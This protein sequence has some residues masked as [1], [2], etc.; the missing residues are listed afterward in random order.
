MTSYSKDRLK[1]IAQGITGSKIWAYEDT[2]ILADIEESA[3]F[4]TNA[5]DMGIDTGD[6]LFLKAKDGILNKTVRGA[7]IGIVQDTG[8]TQGTVGLSVLIGDT[9]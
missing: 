5:G 6:F 8:A 1:L 7:A 3:G 4:F 9:S 2:G